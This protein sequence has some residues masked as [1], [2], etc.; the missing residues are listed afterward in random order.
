VGEIS[1]VLEEPSIVPGI[2]LLLAWMALA[3]FAVNWQEVWP[4]LARGAWVPL[5]LLMFVVALA[6]SR[7]APVPILNFWAQLLGVAVLVGLTLFC[8]WVQGA[9]HGAPPAVEIEPELA[10]EHDHGPEPGPHE[11]LGPA[12]PPQ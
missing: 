3:L 6:W 8:G 9:L 4:V 10:D 1:R 11:A 12:H 7:L 5:V 2:L